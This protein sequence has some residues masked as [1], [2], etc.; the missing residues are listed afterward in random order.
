MAQRGAFAGWG[1][2]INDIVLSSIS[3][4]AC[5][6]NLQVAGSR[7]A[8]MPAEAALRDELRQALALGDKVCL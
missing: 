4:L 5:A 1:E 3:H 6:Q 8:A 2:E 7:T